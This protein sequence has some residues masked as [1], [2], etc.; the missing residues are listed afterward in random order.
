MKIFLS[1]TF[2][3]IPML[4]EFCDTMY[5]CQAVCKSTRSA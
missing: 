5:T 1:R 3:I 2:L 4:M